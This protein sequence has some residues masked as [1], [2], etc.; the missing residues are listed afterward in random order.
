MQKHESFYIFCYLCISTRLC[1]D[2]KTKVVIYYFLRVGIFFMKD[3]DFQLRCFEILSMIGGD[4]VDGRSRFFILTRGIASMKG[5]IFFK[6]RFSVWQLEILGLDIGDLV[7]GG[8]PNKEMIKKK[9]FEV[10]IRR[11]WKLG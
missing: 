3:W 9:L 6:S 11:Y 4:F 2:Q 5:R 8:R 1:Y 7:G 10:R